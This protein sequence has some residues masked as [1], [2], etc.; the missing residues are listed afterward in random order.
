MAMLVLRQFKTVWFK[1]TMNVV[2]NVE[3][4]DHCRGASEKTKDLRLA[5]MGYK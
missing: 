4:D 2:T 1:L 3:N 5:A